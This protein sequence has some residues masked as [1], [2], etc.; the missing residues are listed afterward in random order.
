MLKLFLFALLAVL[1]WPVALAVALLYP[2]LW[3]LS[4]PFRIAGLAVTG[5]LA[6]LSLIL[7]A[8]V[9]VLRTL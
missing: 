8:P 2:I 7:L 1:C 3:L 9:R 6:L 5:I 4:L